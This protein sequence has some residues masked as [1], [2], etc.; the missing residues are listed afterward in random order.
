MK[1]SFVS[2]VLVLLGSAALVS[3]ATAVSEPPPP[4]APLVGAEDEAPPKYLGVKGCK[5]CHISKKKGAQYKVWEKAA[6][7]KAYES[8]SSD[9]GKEIASEKGIDDPAKSEKC[10]VCH[11]TA[12]T[13]PA[14]H[15]SDKYEVSEGVGCEACHGPGEFY[16]DREVFE[17]ESDVWYAKGL[18]KP[19]EKTCLRCHDEG[20][21]ARM[22]D[23]IAEEPF[24]FE[25]YFE[26]IAHPIPEGGRGGDG[27][28]E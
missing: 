8:L 23:R 6:H 7:A 24:D 5:K 18:R 20:G 14:E 3:A 15:V 4:K 2:P 17:Q 1:K 19:D 13:Q 22:H 21:E 27:D 25:K 11:S 26:K 12:G 10:L 28:D 9:K 16:A